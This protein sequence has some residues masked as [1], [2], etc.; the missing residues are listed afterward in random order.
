ME[1]GDRVAY[2]AVI[3]SRT[4]GVL[5]GRQENK[6]RNR[7]HDLIKTTGIDKEEGG[8]PKDPAHQQHKHAEVRPKKAIYHSPRLHFVHVYRHPHQDDR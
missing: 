1:T 5:S 3:V 6:P 7:R 2:A 8:E 4:R